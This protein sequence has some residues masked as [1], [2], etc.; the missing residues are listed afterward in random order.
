[1]V[2][3]DLIVVIP[4]SNMRE[5]EFLLNSPKSLTYQKF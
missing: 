2:D 3:G 5:A 4:T 1:M